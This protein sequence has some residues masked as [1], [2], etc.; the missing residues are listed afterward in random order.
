MYSAE[1]RIPQRMDFVVLF[2]RVFQYHSFGLSVSIIRVH[3][4]Q[5]GAG[6]LVVGDGG[7]GLLDRLVR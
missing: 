2:P 1:E 5:G 3:L 4:C 7:D 6:E